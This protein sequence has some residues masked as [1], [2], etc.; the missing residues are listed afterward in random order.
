[1][2]TVSKRMETVISMVTKGNRVADIGTDHGYVP[3]A[4]VQRKWIKKAIAM[5]VRKG[6]L[7]KAM[8]N[9]QAY[10]MDE[11]IETRLSDGME[12]LE[13]GEADTIII[14]GMGGELMARILRDGARVLDSVQ[15]VIVQPQSEIYKVRMQLHQMGFQIVEEK[16]LIDEGKYYT[17]MKA[18]KGRECCDNEVQYYFG[19]LLL[20][21]KDQVLY[22]W[23]QKEYATSEALYQKLK[24]IN[25]EAGLARREQLLHILELLKG[26]L[27][28]Y[29]A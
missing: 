6:P 20:E 24:D 27:S 4:L 15:E 8:D 10:H 3:I 9:I 19:K 2:I 11:Q 17:A 23:L 28:Y 25:S 26:G 1:M 5:D 22:E 14:A 12:K 18:I 21:Q 16:M 29:E 13:A 7:Q